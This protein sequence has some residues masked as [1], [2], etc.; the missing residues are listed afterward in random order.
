MPPRPVGIREARIQA[1]IQRLPKQ[2]APWMYFTD[3]G[4]M[5]HPAFRH[6]GF[7]DEY[8]GWTITY[9]AADRS[10]IARGGGQRVVGFSRKLELYKWCRDNSLTGQP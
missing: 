6:G 8:H 4:E 7:S 1:L 10:Y 3:A 9:D 5:R 2:V